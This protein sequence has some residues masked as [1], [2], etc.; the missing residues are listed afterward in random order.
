MEKNEK[1]LYIK[2]VP[3][4]YVSLVLFDL[5]VKCG[6]LYHKNVPECQHLKIVLLLFLFFID[7]LSYKKNS[8]DSTE[9]L[10]LNDFHPHTGT[11][12]YIYIH[13]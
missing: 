5:V 13:S 7:Y 10:M 4:L 8:S 3:S 9:I 11:F 1:K 2:G 12:T 6:K